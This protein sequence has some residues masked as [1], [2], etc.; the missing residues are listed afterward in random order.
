LIQGARESGVRAIAVFKRSALDVMRSTYSMHN[1]PTAAIAGITS[2]SSMSHQATPT[3]TFA[4]TM[5]QRNAVCLRALLA[6]CTMS[7]A[8]SAS[9]AARPV[10]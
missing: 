8:T 2:E 10:R 5:P 9:E 6:V 7:H 4:A 1:T 3:M